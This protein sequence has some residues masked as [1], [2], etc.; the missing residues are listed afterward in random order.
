MAVYDDQ[1]ID[2]KV[3]GRKAYYPFSVTDGGGD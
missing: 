3:G 1:K 2:K